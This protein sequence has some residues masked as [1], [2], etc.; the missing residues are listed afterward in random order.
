M[1]LTEL[2]LIELMLDLSHTVTFFNFLHET[3]IVFAESFDDGVKSTLTVIPGSIFV[4]G[5]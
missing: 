3:H 1:S 5:G 2:L 4:S